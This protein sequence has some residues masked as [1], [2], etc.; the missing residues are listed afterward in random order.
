MGL[1]NPFTKVS[2]EGMKTKLAIKKTGET[3]VFSDLLKN[4][5]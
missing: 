4:K 3:E 5:F 1:N 2:P